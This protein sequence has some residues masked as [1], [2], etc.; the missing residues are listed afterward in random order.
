MTNFLFLFPNKM[1]I[2]VWRRLLLCLFIQSIGSPVKIEVILE[3]PGIK[4]RNI[5][6]LLIER[7]EI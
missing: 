7:I 3:I 6:S 1:P 2:R 4:V 5:P